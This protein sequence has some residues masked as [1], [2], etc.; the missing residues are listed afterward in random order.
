MVVVVFGLIN[1]HSVDNRLVVVDDFAV[2]C[3]MVGAFIDF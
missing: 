3:G 2:V 1:F